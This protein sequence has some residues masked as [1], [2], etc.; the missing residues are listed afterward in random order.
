MQTQLHGGQGLPG[1]LLQRETSICPGRCCAIVQVPWVSSYLGSSDSLQM[2]IIKYLGLL[3]AGVTLS[4]EALLRFKAL[5]LIAV[6]V[7]RRSLRS[8]HDAFFPYQ[9]LRLIPCSEDQM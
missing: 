9:S 2:R 4:M 7:K 6:T 5:V 3:P 1:Q 8:L